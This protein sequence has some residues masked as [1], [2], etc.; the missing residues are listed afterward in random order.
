VSR[1]NS[2]PAARTPQL[3]RLST[4]HYIK[5]SRIYRPVTTCT[6]KKPRVYRCGYGSLHPVAGHVTG[7]DLNNP[8]YLPSLLQCY[9][10]KGGTYAIPPRNLNHNLNL[11]ILLLL[12]FRAPQ[13]T[14]GEVASIWRTPRTF[15]LHNSSF[16]LALL[17]R[18][19]SVPGHIVGRIQNL[20]NVSATAPSCT[21]YG[22]DGLI[23]IHATA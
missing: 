4:T 7:S 20:L 19:Q 18:P 3:I 16:I 10:S 15:I 23:P 14:A 21:W 6:F 13:V 11:L 2:T 17:G 22:W 12:R 8:S 1:L 9:R 5:I